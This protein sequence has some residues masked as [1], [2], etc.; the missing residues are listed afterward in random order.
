[1]KVIL[2]GGVVKDTKKKLMFFVRI[3]NLSDGRKTIIPS[4]FMIAVHSG[5]SKTSPVWV[6]PKKERPVPGVKFLLANTVLPGQTVEG[7]LRYKVKNP[8]GIIFAAAI[9]RD[10]DS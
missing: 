10:M 7:F 9:G 6:S 3:T 2:A 1:M 5:D 8:K 4:N